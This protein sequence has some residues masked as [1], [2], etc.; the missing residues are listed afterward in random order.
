MSI[1]EEPRNGDYAAYIATLERQR[2]AA[3]SAQPAAVASQATAQLNS[4][5]ERA[6]ASASTAPCAAPQPGNASRPA[7][8]TRASGPAGRPAQGMQIPSSKPDAQAQRLARLRRTRSLW[9]AIIG[10]VAAWHG[11]TQMTQLWR[12]GSVTV[13]AAIPGLFMIGLGLILLRS[14]FKLRGLARTNAPVRAVRGPNGDRP[15]PSG[16]G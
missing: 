10:L 15:D 6:H 7:P 1:P 13:Q 11:V 3:A 5:Y 16:G 8:H 2:S 9:L 4:S 14:A 12:A